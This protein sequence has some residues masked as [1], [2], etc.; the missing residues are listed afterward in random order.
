[1]PCGYGGT[2]V[3]NEWTMVSIPCKISGQTV[4]TI[5]G[6]DG[7]GTYDTNW[8]VY[9]QNASNYSGKS[10]D[11][12][13]LDETSS[14]EQGKSY[15]IIADANRTWK[16]DST[17]SSIRTDLNTTIV[18][19][20]DVV[21]GTYPIALPTADQ[22]VSGEIYAKVM[23]GNPFA[24]SFEWTNVQYYSVS[25]A[26]I[27]LSTAET[28]NYMDSTAYMY[29]SSSTTGQPYTAVTSTPGVGSKTVPVNKGLWIKML[30]NAQSGDKLL[31]PLEK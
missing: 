8:V 13:K 26:N 19:N 9:E 20:P 29:D 1:M 6:D 31:I 10:A 18:P 28:S 15:W 24:R 12:I 5:F 4:A 22:N 14:I 3:D 30:A 7:L 23:V 25:D 27:S 2:L 16:V 17:A 21:A 11:Y